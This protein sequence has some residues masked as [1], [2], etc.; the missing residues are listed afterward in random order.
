MIS[1]VCIFS[2]VGRSAHRQIWRMIRMISLYVCILRMRDGSA[3]R[4]IDRSIT[5]YRLTSKYIKYV[6]HVD[7]QTA[8]RL[9][10]YM[11]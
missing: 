8:L 1:H 3:G 6:R 2:M 11:D 4:Q 9:N 7:R 5:K 10:I